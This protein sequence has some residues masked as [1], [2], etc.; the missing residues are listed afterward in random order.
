MS[1]S[2]CLAVQSEHTDH[3]NL[4]ESAKEHHRL[5]SAILASGTRRY[6]YLVCRGTCRVKDPDVACRNA[7]TA[8][9]DQYAT[10][11]LNPGF[12]SPTSGR[13]LGS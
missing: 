11:Y 4:L 10:L 1:T 3:W 13:E 5:Y 12:S 6:S 8:D 2:A 9:S 7:T